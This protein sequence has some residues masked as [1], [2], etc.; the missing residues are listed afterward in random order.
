MRASSG[1]GSGAKSGPV[2]VRLG[3]VLPW[4]EDGARDLLRQGYSPEQVAERTGFELSRVRRLAPSKR[5]LAARLA[6]RR[7][8]TA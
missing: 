1:K 3:N 2:R 5:P 4:D 8:Y 7:G 6:Q